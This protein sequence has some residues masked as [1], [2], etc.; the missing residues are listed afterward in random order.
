VTLPPHGRDELLRSIAATARETFQAVAC[1]LAVLEPDE[2]HLL[3]RV[4]VGVGAD[5]IVGRRLP[6]G[7][8]IA[9]W[10]ASS[11]EAI[12]VENVESDPRF[13]RDLAES[14][15]YVP[16]SIMV[17]PA[18]V[19]DHLY[20]V[21]EILD[22]G[23]TGGAQEPGLSTL[24]LFGHQAA[25]VLRLSDELDELP[26]TAF[27]AS[28]S[29]LEHQQPPSSFTPLER[30]GREGLDRVFAQLSRMGGAEQETAIMLI[31]AL[32]AYIERRRGP[33]GVV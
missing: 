10:A 29:S 32:I 6:V 3:F 22:R 9:G 19:E 15:G 18:E 28:A 21:I 20:G 8:G 30:R 17:V 24:A 33:A 13:A 11:G 12:A 7:R 27:S 26:A 31:D 4:A 1:S 14:T 2:E 5:D 23:S 25:L 16:R